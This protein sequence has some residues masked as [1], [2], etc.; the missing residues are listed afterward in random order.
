MNA[1]IPG[2]FD[3]KRFQAAHPTRYMDVGIAEGHSVSFA[4]GF[5]KNGMKP[6]LFHSSFFLPR[7]YDQLSHDLAINELPA[8]ILV[9]QGNISKSDI[10]HQGLF[11]IP[12]LNSIPNV[13]YL[14]P[15]DKQDLL[16]MIDWALL[17][18][19]GPIAIRIPSGPVIEGD[20]PV[21]SYSAPH[22]QT[23]QKGQQ[24]ALLGLGNFLELAKN[25]AAL[26]ASELGITATIIDPQFASELDEATLQELG[27]DHDCVVTFEDGSLTGGF[28]EMVSSFYGPAAVKTLNYGAQK[29]FTDNVPTAELYE[30][31]HLNPQQILEDLKELLIES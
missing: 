8:V 24:V 26:L 5:A 20:A 21:I 7:A 3:L 28:G 2:M 29:E 23:I 13:R 30:R 19:K 15:A 1:A 11:D 12:M 14:A 31:Y 18:E 4:A 17:Q 27:K 9:G 6:L 25:V 10:T 22:Y 16:A